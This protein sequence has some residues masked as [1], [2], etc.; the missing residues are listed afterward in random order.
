MTDWFAASPT[1]LLAV[2]LSTLGIYAAVILFTQIAGLR[3]FS[4]MSGFDFAMTVAVG[5]IVASAILTDS[6]PLLQAVVGLATIYLLQITVAVLRQKSDLV[7][8][9][10][11]NEPLLIMT[12][13]G[14]LHDNLRRARMTESDLWA[15]LREA[16]VIQPEEVRAVVMETTGDVSVLHG[17]PDGSPLH[18][19]LLTSVRDAHRVPGIADADVPDSHGD[20]FA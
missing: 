8:R 11:D 2:V 13:E 7:S 12:S 17:P 14:I 5:S 16:N 9:L 15:K 4:K 3:S 10:V 19:K 1:A 6:P 20:P 18:P